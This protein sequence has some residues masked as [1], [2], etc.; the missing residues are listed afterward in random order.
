[1]QIYVNFVEQDNFI[2][3][4]I[5]LSVGS[6][7]FLKRKHVKFIARANRISCEVFNFFTPEHSATTYFCTIL[8][9]LKLFDATSFLVATGRI[10]V[11][12]QFV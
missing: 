10:K 1:M 7:R 12:H 5:S 3:K 2:I 4:F 11:F 9:F 6:T 8:P